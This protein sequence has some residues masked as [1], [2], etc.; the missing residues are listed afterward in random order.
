M[1][2]SMPLLPQEMD[3]NTL[4]TLGSMGNHEAR[5]E[6]VKR[7]IMTKDKVSYEEACEIF[8]KIQDKNLEFTT[9]LSLPYQIGIAVALTGGFL[10]F[11]MVFDL[12]T[13]EWFNT[14]FVTTGK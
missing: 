5:K 4:V 12:S 9:L 6:I 3:N 13:A 2:S 7:H 10:S 14:H 1:V 11:P 8:R